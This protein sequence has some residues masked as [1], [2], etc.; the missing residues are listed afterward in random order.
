MSTYCNFD[1]LDKEFILCAVNMNIKNNFINFAVTVMDSCNNKVKICEFIDNDF[2]TS[3][4]NILIQIAPTHED[5]KY[6]ILGNFPLDFFA[7][8]FQNL[9]EK[10]EIVDNK[11]VFI[12]NKEFSDNKN[13]DFFSTIKLLLATSDNEQNNPLFS[14]NELIFALSTLNSTINYTRILQFENFQNKFFLEKFNVNEF[15]GLDMT[16]V[17]CLNLFDNFDDKKQYS[18]SKLNKT[19]NKNSV[20]AVLNNCCTRFGSRMLRSWM[21]QPLQEKEEIDTRLNMVELLLSSN[22]FKREIRDS[23]L[24]K[25]DDIQTINMNLSKYISKNDENLVKLNDCAKLQNTINICKN[26]LFYLKCYEGPHSELLFERYVKHLDDIII[27]LG[28]LEEMFSKTLVFDNKSREYVINFKL[29]PELAIIQEQV[30]E[31]WQEIEQI[32]SNV[33]NEIYSKSAKPK[34]IKITEY[35]CNGFALEIPKSDGDNFMKNSNKSSNFK[36]VN[37]NKAALVINSQELRNLSESYRKLKSEYRSHEKIFHQKVLKVT[38]SYHPLF[39]RLI[40]LLSELDV[41]SSFA[42][43]VEDSKEVYAK[44]ILTNNNADRLLLLKDSRHIILEWNAD[45]IKK[46]NPNNKNLIAN[47]CE[48]KEGGNIKLITG[49]NMGGKSTYLR[50]VGICVLLAHIGMYLP[51]TSATV[52]IIDQIFTRVGAGDLMLKGISTY[53][54]EMI[55]VCSLIKSA[56]TRSLMLIDELGRGTSTDDG[57]GISYAILYHISTEINCFCLF[58]THFFELTAMENLLKN[59]K[60]YYMSYAVLNGELLMEY[61][62]LPGKANNSFGVNLFKSLKFDEDTCQALEKFISA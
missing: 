8:K 14:K 10:L 16:C 11:Q 42:T 51:A 4:E 29:N 30:D 9:I 17:K 48:M 43:V 22:Y 56:T 34:K 3:L 40:Y 18:F 46:N 39:E 38:S 36:I 57:V 15:M 35:A 62:I 26:L 19:Q 33:E 27:R 2:F 21:L 61:K 5:I 7:Q 31:C 37:T 58:A 52:P 12:N 47:D 50:Q 32:K 54:N 53:M 13:I 28:K 59:L 25:I 20:F 41:L 49:I 1:F 45:I 55:E 23:Y 6:Y 60:N 44:P 24:S